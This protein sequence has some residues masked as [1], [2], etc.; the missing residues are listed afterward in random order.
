MTDYSPQELATKRRKLAQ[1]YNEK[2]KELASLKKKKAFTIIEFMGE[3][4]TVSKAELYYDIT[5]DGQKY[6]ELEMYCRGLLELMR[7]IK[8]EVDIANNEAFNNY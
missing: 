7:S 5:E 4:K 6:I 2:M 8:T 1:E 3:H